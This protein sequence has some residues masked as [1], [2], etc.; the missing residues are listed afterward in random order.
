MR[1]RITTDQVET[2]QKW[3]LN[4]IF[5]SPALCL[6]QML[7]FLMDSPA[8]QR[9]ENNWLMTRQCFDPATEIVLHCLHRHATLTACVPK[10]PLKIS[11]HFP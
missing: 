1:R 11:P 9:A 10:R 7:S 6:I 4:I 8:L 3:A 5:T 2:V